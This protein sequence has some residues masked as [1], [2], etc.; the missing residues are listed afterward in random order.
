MG[1]FY[2]QWGIGAALVIGGLEGAFVVRQSGVS[3]ELRRETSR[4]AGGG[5]VEWSGDYVAARNRANFVGRA[6]AVLV[7][8]TIVVMTVQ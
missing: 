4:R 6:M 5:E 7:A 2:V 3:A 8:A 1:Q